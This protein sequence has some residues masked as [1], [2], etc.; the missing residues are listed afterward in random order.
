MSRLDAEECGWSPGDDA[1]SPEYIIMVKGLD[2][3]PV[4][5]SI[6]G[7]ML[8]LEG[9]TVAQALAWHRED[10]GA[11]DETELTAEAVA[12]ACD[13]ER[14]YDHGPWPCVWIDETGALRTGTVEIEEVETDD[15][16]D[17]CPVCTR[18]GCAGYCA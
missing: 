6:I 5:L 1:P 16:P 18:R 3:V 9:L 2:R 8:C 11:P 15:A 14:G 4:K 7:A 10:D 13:G 17:E 12:E